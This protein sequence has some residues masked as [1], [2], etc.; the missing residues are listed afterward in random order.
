MKDCAAQ[1]E[2]VGPGEA[3]VNK[4]NYDNHY[5][6]KY[7]RCYVR[8]SWTISQ[9][10]PVSGLGVRLIDAFEHSTIAVST[11]TSPESKANCFVESTDR[12]LIKVVDCSAA[13]AF[14]YDHMSN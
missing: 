4:G 1:A 3:A 13:A 12:Q 9:G 5:S 6:P 8:I 7:D 14:I 2:K 11:I 10:E